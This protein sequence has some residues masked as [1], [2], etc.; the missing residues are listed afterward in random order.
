MTTW[1][2]RLDVV[3]V[4]RVGSFINWDN[5][6]NSYNEFSLFVCILKRVFF[7]NKLQ[8]KSPKMYISLF[9]SSICLIS[10]SKWSKNSAFAF[11]GR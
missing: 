7:S 10:F 2:I 8:F 3:I 6:Y 1:S 11:G 9:L 4:T 5:W